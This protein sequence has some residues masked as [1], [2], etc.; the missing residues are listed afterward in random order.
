MKHLRSIALLVLAAAMLLSLLGCAPKE[1]A[2]TTP[3]S[4]EAPGAEAPSEGSP[5]KLTMLVPNNS[6]QYIKF[7][8]R[9]EYPVWQ[10]LKALFAAKGL[11]LEFELIPA[12]QYPTTLQ[13]RI[14]SG[15][16]LPD[17][18]CLTPFDDASAMD[19]ANKGTILPI[20]TI[21]DQYSDGTF[22]RFIREQYPFMAQLTT[23][24]DGNIY[25]YTSIQAQT[26][27]GKPAPTCRV[28]NI[29][30]D[31]LDALD[32][33]APKTA[34][35]FITVMKA[36]QE[37]DMNGNG[38]ADEI[39]TVDT[40]GDFFMTGIAQW[41]GV[42]NYLTSVD[43]VNNKIVSPWYQEGIQD[44]LKYMQRLVAEGLLDPDLIGASY[45][46][47][48]QRMVENK[49]G[50]TFDYCMQMWLEPSINA[51]DP[52][53]LPIANLDTGYDPY[54]II[55]PSF[56]SWQKW[57]VTKDC[58]NPEAVAALLDVLYSARYEELTA[59]GIEG[60]TYE[61][62][63]GDRQLMEG[64]GG[65]FWEQNAA[66]R[67]SSGGPLWAGCVFPTVSLYTMESQF[68]SRPEHK[69]DFQKSVAFQQNVY[70]DAKY[71]YMAIATDQQNQR[72]AELITDLSTYSS[73]LVTDF[74]LG[75]ASFDD[76]DKHIA[77]LQELGLDE[78]IAIEQSQYDAFLA[79]SK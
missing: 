19:L 38:V 2:L 79:F 48:N 17:I 16:D 47:T 22:N 50:A 10:E 32:L 39:V 12:D 40:S 27:Q 62:V 6:N 24:P 76:W 63:N 54:I 11:E 59:W 26:Y 23:A 68:T 72:K 73:E 65:A 46:Q 37:N 42:G 8:E 29:R 25:W 34:E 45:E 60:K 49:V 30:K 3:P 9:E 43:V 1:P 78:L 28:I 21:A 75:R 33:E 14:A 67:N 51:E 7:D 13:T 18:V 58:K 70:P 74:I 52:Q 4:Q 5:M 77:Q 71:C 61:V 31:W 41:F 55:E 57:A 35:E 20:N 36:F 15:T 64:V 53:F 66:D 69:N 56:F 44:Y